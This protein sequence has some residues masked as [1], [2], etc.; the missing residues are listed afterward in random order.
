MHNKFNRGLNRLVRYIHRTYKNKLA[1]I[2]MFLIGWLSAK[3]SGDATFFI[4]MLI[5]VWPVFLTRED[6]FYKPED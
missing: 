1:A 2:A 5:I 6:I 4:L 3:I